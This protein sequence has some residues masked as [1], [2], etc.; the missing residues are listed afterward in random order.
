LIAAFVV[1]DRAEALQVPQSVIGERVGQSVAVDVSDPAS[2]AELSNFSYEK[3][4]KATLEKKA[5]SGNANWHPMILGQR[6][7]LS[8]RLRRRSGA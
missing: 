6:S 1:A 3:W 2:I 8:I 7:Y 5:I 4:R